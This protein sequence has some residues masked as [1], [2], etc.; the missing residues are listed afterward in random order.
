MSKKKI[1]PGLTRYLISYK[2]LDN[3]TLYAYLFKHETK[4]PGLIVI[5]GSESGIKYTSGIK[6]DYNNKNALFL[7]KKGFNVITAE[8]RGDGFLGSTPWYRINANANSIGKSYQGVILQDHIL[9][10]NILYSLDVTDKHNI[11]AAGVSL[12]AEQSIYLTSIDERIKAIVAFGWLSDKKA[13]LT[14]HRPC[15]SVHNLYTFFDNSD[16]PAM[17]APR[18]ALYSIG[19]KEDI[20][21]IDSFTIERARRVN[22]LF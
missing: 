2:S 10:L 1:Q 19:K 5:S 3:V 13:L 18:G 17:I 12:G 22:G 14:G 4:K 16:I 11:F 20:N 6:K 7:A 9:A 8:N 21:H 15:W